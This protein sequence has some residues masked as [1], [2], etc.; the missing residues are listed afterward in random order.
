M[1]TQPQCIVLQHLE[2]GSQWP[3]PVNPWVAEWADGHKRRGGRQ[4]RADKQEKGATG[5]AMGGDGD[6]MAMAMT[7]MTVGQ[8]DRRGRGVTSPSAY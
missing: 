5:A 2:H 1:E 7:R 6:R 8:D 3:S 4:R